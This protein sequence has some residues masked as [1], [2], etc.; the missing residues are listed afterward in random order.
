MLTRRVH[1][2]GKGAIY[3]DQSAPNKQ[4]DHSQ[5]RTP[6]DAQGLRDGSFAWGD[7]SYEPESVELVAGQT[8]TLGVTNTV[9][10]VYSDIT[11]TKD[12]TG[13]ADGLV[14][15]DRRSR[16]PSAAGTAPTPRS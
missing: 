15:T 9:V 3:R 13:P 2:F 5:A 7:P 6:C 4:F 14:P 1:V 16:E 10:R 8:A 11:V 12:V